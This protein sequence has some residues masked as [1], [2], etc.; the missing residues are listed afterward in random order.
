M[1]HPVNHSNT[2]PPLGYNSLGVIIKDTILSIA[3]ITFSKA[4][5]KALQRSFPLAAIVLRTVPLITVIGF[6]VRR[7]MGQLQA[8][9]SPPPYSSS[10]NHSYGWY[11]PS[12]FIDWNNARQRPNSYN[13]YNR[14]HSPMNNNISSINIPLNSPTNYRSDLS[15]NS[16][17]TYSNAVHNTAHNVASSIFGDRDDH[18]QQSS[19]TNIANPPRVQNI[20]YSSGGLNP[21]E[22]RQ[23]REYNQAIPSQNILLNSSGGL[24][25]VG[26]RQ[27]PRDYSQAIPS[28]NVISNSS[29][30]LNPVG[31][32]QQPRDYSQAIPN[33]QPT[34]I[35]HPLMNNTFS[36]TQQSPT[37]ILYPSLS[38]SAP[39]QQVE[40]NS[41]GSRLNHVSKR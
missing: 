3:L 34:N 9:D 14:G 30:G 12:R 41:A 32:R 11:N 18:K 22:S 2:A 10:S 13:N 15:N 4:G 31:S 23:T 33:T 17:P 37:N 25:P 1:I 28:Q 29:G 26:P 6:F 27:Q 20:S 38:P 21:V 24:N 8:D 7:L 36:S 39:L 40:P 35:S 5:A 16:L 19:R